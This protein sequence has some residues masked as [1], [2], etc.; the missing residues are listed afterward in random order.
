MTTPTGTSA[1]NP[2]IEAAL[3][4]IL[5]EVQPGQRPYSSDSYLPAHLIEQAQ[6]A[7]DRVNDVDLATSQHAFNALSVASWHCARGE[8]P[9]ALARLRRAQ[10]HIRSAMEGGAQ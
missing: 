4:A 7:L 1:K 10:A 8:M 6:A 9:Q 2:T 5:S 3:R